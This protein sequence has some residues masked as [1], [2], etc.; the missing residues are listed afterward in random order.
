MRPR[1]TVLVL[2]LTAIDALAE[3]PPTL[4][5]NDV[6]MNG[7]PTLGQWKRG[8]SVTLGFPLIT[9]RASIGLADRLDV[10]LGFQ[11][12]FGL[13]N[14]FLVHVK[15]ALYRGTSWS[16]AAAVEGS[17]AFFVQSAADEQRGARWLTGRRNYGV[18]PSLI[19]TWQ[20]E[21]ARSAR[22]FAQVSYLLT[23][24]V[25]MAALGHN[26]STHLGAEL[27]LSPK[28]SFVFMFG[29]GVHGRAEDSPVMPDASLGLAF[30]F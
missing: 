15:V 7:A 12:F 26:V 17:G 20:G 3:D 8:A 10:G 30:G 21:S 11:T 14:E 2:A 6:S 9:A 22:L 28:V 13:M 23:F 16:L 1:L 29:L 27:P 18:S 4:E 24:E 25:P 5:R 19:L